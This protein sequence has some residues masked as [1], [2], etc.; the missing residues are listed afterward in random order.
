VLAGVE[1]GDDAGVLEAREDPHLALEPAPLS[2]IEAEACVEELDR[3]VD[4]GGAPSPEDD[5]R[6]AASEA[7]FDGVGAD[8]LRQVHPASLAAARG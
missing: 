4:P 8:A 2:V 5:P 7:A 3:H 1:D 6:G